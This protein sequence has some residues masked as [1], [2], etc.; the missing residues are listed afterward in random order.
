MP[1]SDN[2]IHSATNGELTKWNFWIDR[3]GTFTDIVARTPG[4][5]LRARKLLSESPEAYPDAALQGIPDSPGVASSQPIS[6]ANIQSVKKG[7]TVAT[8]ALLE[9]QGDWVLLLTNEGFADALEIGYQARPKLFDRE[10]VKCGSND[11]RRS[12]G[13]AEKLAGPVQVRSDKNDAVLIQ[14]SSG[15]G[16]GE[17]DTKESTT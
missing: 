11:L 8:N 6:A 13:L 1:E 5:E 9:R 2:S 16:Y 10:I 7:T 15:G 12:D 4:G 3:A 14:T 17:E